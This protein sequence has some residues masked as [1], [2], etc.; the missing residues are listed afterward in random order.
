MAKI[1]IEKMEGYFLH[2][3]TLVCVVTTKALGKEDAMACA[4]NSFISAAPPLYGVSISPRRYTHELILNSGQFAINF[5]PFDKAE[6]VAQMGAVSGRDMDKLARFGIETEAPLKLQCPIL[7]D[8]Y[9]SYECQ[10]YD[11][12]T[13]GDHEWFVGEIVAAHYLEE[14]AAENMI[15]LD[16]IK[17]TL[18]LGAERYLSSANEV[19]I[20]LERER[21]RTQ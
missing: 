20:H 12:H 2:Y 4:W 16:N 8:A 13:Y 9:A 14:A 19:V 5:V 15:N 17:P 1:R 11:H 7:K 3:P 21:Y 18:Y 10:L 6:L